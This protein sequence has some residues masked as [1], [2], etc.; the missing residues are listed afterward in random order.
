MEN[1]MQIIIDSKQWFNQFLS[2]Q[3]SLDILFIETMVK[4]CFCLNISTKLAL[5]CTTNTNQFALFFAME[6]LFNWDSLP[7]SLNSHCDA[8]SYKK[9]KHK[10][11]KAYS[12]SIQKEPTVKRCLLILDFKPLRSQVKGKHSIGREFQSLAVQA[13]KLLT[14]TQLYHLGMLT[15]KLYNLSE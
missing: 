14:Q 8:Q 11:I 7:A 6:I 2:S 13:K 3:S 4:I 5:T 12:K 1:F 15:E 10:K 9:K